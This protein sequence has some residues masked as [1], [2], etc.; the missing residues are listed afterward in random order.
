[1]TQKWLAG[2]LPRVTPDDSKVT[3]ILFEDFLSQVLG[4]F[5]VGLPES[6]LSS[7]CVSVK[8]GGRPLQQP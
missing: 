6:L 8:L 3:T 5:G 4:H 7:F 1:M 2:S